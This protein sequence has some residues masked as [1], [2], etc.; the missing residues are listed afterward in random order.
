MRTVRLADQRSNREIVREVTRVFHNI[1][2]GALLRGNGGR[3]PVQ[4]ACATS[5][6]AVALHRLV[7]E[8]IIAALVLNLV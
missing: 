7:V 4:I 1:G 6:H 5:T 2:D 3:A 8:S